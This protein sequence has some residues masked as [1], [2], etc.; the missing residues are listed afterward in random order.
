[1]KFF[2]MILVGVLFTGAAFARASRVR[3]YV[4]KSGKYVASY[5]RTTPNK[6]KADNWSAKGNVNPDTGKAGTKK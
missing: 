3:G 6:T 5:R 2:T 4:K 1:M